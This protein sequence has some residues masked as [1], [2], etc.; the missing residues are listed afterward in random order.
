MLYLLAAASQAESCETVRGDHE[1]F[2][3]WANGALKRLEPARPNAPTKAERAEWEAFEKVVAVAI[4]EL[5][6][7]Y[8]NCVEN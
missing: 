7:R 1:R 5:N 4:A 6:R 8:A 2:K 3:N